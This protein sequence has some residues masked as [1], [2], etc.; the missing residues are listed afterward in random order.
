MEARVALLPES[1][2]HVR[3]GTV[4]LVCTENYVQ[5]TSNQYGTYDSRKTVIHYSAGETFLSDATVRNG[6]LHSTDVRLAVP[7]DA[8]PTMSGIKVSNVQ[9]GIT[10]GG[11]PPSSTWRERGTY[12]S[13][14]GYRSEST[15]V[16]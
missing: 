2:F 12:D 5:R 14:S 7:A 13:I 9:P 10:W 15:R 3:Q 1:D 11:S 6:L 4:A 8:M 16:R